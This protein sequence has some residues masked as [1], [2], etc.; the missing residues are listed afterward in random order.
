LGSSLDDDCARR[1]ESEHVHLGLVPEHDR[2]RMILDQIS[3]E[4]N[5]GLLERDGPREV[6][7]D[8]GD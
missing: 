5:S 2:R 6:E 7:A 1:D 8:L 3:D 4:L